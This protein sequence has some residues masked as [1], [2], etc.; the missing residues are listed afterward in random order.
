M[1]IGRWI[2][3]TRNSMQ[4][5]GFLK[6]TC[7]LAPRTRGITLEGL[8]NRLRGL[9]SR[10]I[11]IDLDCEPEVRRYI[12]DR[13][14]FTSRYKD[15]PP[16][17]TLARQDSSG[18][19]IDIEIQD[20]YLAQAGIP[21]Q[22]GN[23]TPDVYEDI[24]R[25]AVNLGLLR[26][27]NYSLPARGQLL[28]LLAH[29]AASPWTELDFGHNPFAL[30]LPEKALFLYLLLEQDGDVLLRLYPRLVELEEPF[31]R[32]IAGD[33]LP[34]VFREIHAVYQL[35]ARTA[36]DVTQVRSLLTMADFIQERKGKPSDGTGRTREQRITMRLEAFV[37][38]GFL[39]KP[40][41]T[42]YEYVF[43]PAG[44]SLLSGV[45]ALE[46]VGLFLQGSFL[47]LLAKSLAIPARQ[48]ADPV[49]IV[50]S[51][52][53]GYEAL[54]S[55]TGYAPIEEVLLYTSSKALASDAPWFFELSAGMQAVKEVQMRYPQGLRFNVDRQ[56]NLRYLKLER[57]LLDALQSSPRL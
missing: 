42:K 24:P 3:Y 7:A 20:Y 19:T 17:E 6:A 39:A 9:V 25:W 16:T 35:C 29:N 31:H 43:T 34:M 2:E 44:R 49:E 48:S 1:P 40:D 51:L 52:F 23:L 10:R 11:R 56:G 4:R 45:P 47:A 8:A 37:D 54:R 28:L 46:A 21:S 57:S 30:S 38:L 55:A 15:F 41:T 50:S 26:D 27:L 18:H 36:A 13:R 14:L 32:S 53:E 12:V 33:I 22:T 5:L